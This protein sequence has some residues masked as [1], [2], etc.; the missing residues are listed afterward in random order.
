MTDAGKVVTGLKV[1]DNAKTITIL[2]AENQRTEI[3]RD[4]IEELKVSEKSLMPENL[5][6]TLGERQL[7]DLFSYLRS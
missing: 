2:D 7:R 5:L 3:H 6:Q 4:I 1:E